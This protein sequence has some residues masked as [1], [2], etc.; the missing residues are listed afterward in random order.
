[1]RRRLRLVAGLALALVALASAVAA[2]AQTRTPGASLT[3]V[4]VGVPGDSL[5]F[6][7]WFLAKQDGAFRRNGLDVK[8]VYLSS[9]VIPAALLAGSIQATPLI[10]TVMQAGLAG[11]HVKAVANLVTRP[12]YELVA[13][14][15]I[16]SMRDLKG[17]TAVAGPPKALP[18]LLLRYFLD[19][20]GLAPD[21]D[22]TILYIG[23]IAARRTLMASG[24]GDA[25][26]ESTKGAL[27][28]RQA[29]PDLH[30]LLVEADMPELLA[31]GVGASEEVLAAAP[32]VITN[33]VRALA[34]SNEDARK[35]PARAAALLA[36]YMKM[37]NDGKVLAAALTAAFSD[38]LTPSRRL[39]EAEAKF[40][41][42]AGGTP[43][44]AEQIMSCWDPRIAEQIDRELAG[45]AETKV[46]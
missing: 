30:P 24:R 32:A 11:S 41:S 15:S 23:A 4:D 22:V 26:V 17:K 20:A 36:A 28:L 25:I 2:S 8:F 34:Q 1:M 6:G 19:R 38:R 21:H 7:S 12:V 35:S 9:D 5:D 14:R 29:L 39:Y 45:P 44:T 46:P 43:V 27:Q 40:L 16:A 42:M 37:P 31:E 33:L 10:G 13:R 3:H 18:T